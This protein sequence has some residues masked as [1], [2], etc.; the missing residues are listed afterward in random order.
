MK[1]DSGEGINGEI[2]EGTLAGAAAEF[3]GAVAVLRARLPNLKVRW[4]QHVPW[5]V[6]WHL[7]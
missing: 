4:R 6:Q 1:E 5:K 7:D 3:A 2:R